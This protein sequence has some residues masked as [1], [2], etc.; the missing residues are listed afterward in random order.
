MAL[1]QRGYV[2]L[3]PHERGSFD[4]GDVHWASGRVYIAN[5]AAGTIEVVDGE[6][7]RHVATVPGYAEASGVVCAQDDALVF[8]AARGAGKVAV[9]DAG[10]G[11][12]LGDLAVGPQPNGLAWDS[13]R[14][15][16]L[17]ADV[18][19]SHARLLDV[20]TG[21]T[22]AAVELPGRP[23]WCIYDEGQDRF[24]VNIRE[25][26][27]VALLAG[28]TIAAV[29]RIPTSSAGP[30]GLDLDRA[31]RRAFV[32]C[33][34]GEVVVLDLATDRQIASIP[35]AG[36]PDAIWYNP[37]RQRLYVAIGDPGVIDVVDGRFMVLDERIATEPGAHTTAYD[38]RRQRLYVFLP[39]R[40]G[41]A[42]YDEV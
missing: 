21:H 23:R 28:E 24:L 32:A 40:C 13:R 20:D 31:G 29:A 6:G 39:R 41:A 3:P 18:R 38:D 8:A 16:L 14:K 36:E 35:I 2:D 42:V 11:R 10:S 7:C 15:R 17:V 1:A 19:D 12:P 37:R 5:T 34:G 4:H 22:L 25:P 33:D 30:H 27:C 9:L 26:A